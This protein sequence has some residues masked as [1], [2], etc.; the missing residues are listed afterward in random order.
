MPKFVAV[1]ETDCPIM[2]NGNPT[3]TQMYIKERLSVSYFDELSQEKDT[4]NKIATIFDSLAHPPPA[5]I[6]AILNNEWSF[7][8]NPSQ[9]ILVVVMESPA[10]Q[11]T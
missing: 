11:S 8:L 4:C 2:H 10:G 3:T 5:M 7:R 1:Y 6:V 9:L